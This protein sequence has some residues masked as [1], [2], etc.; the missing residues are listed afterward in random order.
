MMRKLSGLVVL[1]PALVLAAMPAQARDANDRSLGVEI[2]KERAETRIE[3]L[4]RDKQQKEDA[5]P[6]RNER[7][8][9]R[10]RP[11][12]GTRNF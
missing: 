7:P 5:A 2:S 1:F 6:S 11:Q 3:R 12:R 10:E 8:E 9:P 4:R